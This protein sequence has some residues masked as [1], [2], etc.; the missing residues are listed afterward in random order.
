MTLP[1]PRFRFA[2]DPL[3]PEA[4]RSARQRRFL[5][6]VPLVAGA[7]LAAALVLGSSGG[8]SSTGG[9]RARQTRVAFAVKSVNSSTLLAGTY[10][11]IVSP[12]ALSRHTLAV[13]PLFDV[14]AQFSLV[15]RAHGPRICSFTR[16][17]ERSVTFPGA[18]GT[19]VRIDVN[20]S[21]PPGRIPH[22]CTAFKTFS[23]SYL[24]QP[25]FAG[26][27]IARGLHGIGAAQHPRTRADRLDPSVLA[28]IASSNKQRELN[29]GAIELLKPHSSRLLTRL[30][31]GERVYAV[32]TSSGA[33]CALVERLRV[34]HASNLRKPASAWAC[35]ALTRKVPTTI[36]SFKANPES[37]TFSWGIALDGV[38]AVSWTAG[39][40][41]VI[42][43][44]VR[45]NAWAH[46]G[47]ASFRR[48]TVHFADGR[49]EK[50]QAQ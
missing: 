40:Q 8:G 30:A 14:T 31:N 45:H 43:V 46:L 6:A 22:V 32:A 50:I 17:I 35:S 19:T 23:L 42:T 7:A 4:K 18:N 44:P 10:V 24:R 29:H 38:T 16:K 5:V 21:K 48:F 37:P 28:L 34:P 12:V 27:A 11:T 36:A 26:G 39:R 13:T 9:Q 15:R 20:G 47:N 33:A 1:L 2:V 49:T 3:I 25:A 41:G